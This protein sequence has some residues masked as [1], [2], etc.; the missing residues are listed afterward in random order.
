MDMSYFYGNYHCVMLGDVGGIHFGDDQLIPSLK[1]KCLFAGRD[2]LIMKSVRLSSR[3]NYEPSIVYEKYRTYEV[4][5]NQ[6]GGEEWR[7]LSRMCCSRLTYFLT[8]N[9]TEF[10]G[11]CKRQGRA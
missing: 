2:K 1:C 10:D 11:R 8:L 3:E 4:D 7:Q 5:G 9:A 6:P